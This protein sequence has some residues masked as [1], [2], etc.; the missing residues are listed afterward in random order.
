MCIRDRLYAN[1]SVISITEIGQTDIS[2]SASQNSNNGLQCIT[3]R[4]PCCRFGPNTAGEWFFPDGT[5]VP[6]RVLGTATTFYRNR[7]SDDGTVNLNRINTIVMSPT[8]LFC[9]VVP[10]AID[11]DQTVCIT[12]GKTTV[13][14]M[15]QFHV[16]LQSGPVSIAYI[17]GNLYDL[18]LSVFFS[19]CDDHYLC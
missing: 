12:L 11:I 3:D 15:I 19:Q 9:C 18:F 13:K 5:M 10:D 7:G 4:M 17:T 6:I 2:M 1:N 14:C 8:G 16:H